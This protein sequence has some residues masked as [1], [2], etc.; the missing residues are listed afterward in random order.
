MEETKYLSEKL[1]S[2][3]NDI[4]REFFIYRMKSVGLMHPNS[5]K[6]KKDIALALSTKHFNG[7]DITIQEFMDLYNKLTSNI[8]F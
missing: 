5:K 4:L 1:N 3:E 7:S 2:R 6:L 8:P